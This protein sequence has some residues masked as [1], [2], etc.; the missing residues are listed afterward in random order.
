MGVMS[1]YGIAEAGRQRSAPT[2]TPHAASW[3][4][5]AIKPALLTH[6]LLKRQRYRH[7]LAALNISM[8]KGEEG[9][10]YFKLQRC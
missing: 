2:T 3:A 10:K 6:F 5:G 1:A 4:P 9:G 8:L 7:F